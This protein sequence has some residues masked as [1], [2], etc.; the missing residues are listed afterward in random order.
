M[1]SI[2]YIQTVCASKLALTLFIQQRRNTIANRANFA[3]DNLT[4]DNNGADNNW[5]RFVSSLDVA[6]AP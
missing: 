4:D 5:P 2:E 1:K 3:D 6:V